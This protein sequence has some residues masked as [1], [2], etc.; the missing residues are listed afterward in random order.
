MQTT[1]W[2]SY[3][4]NISSFGGSLSEINMLKYK[5]NRLT[6]HVFANKGKFKWNQHVEM[7]NQQVEC[8][9]FQFLYRTTDFYETSAWVHKI[10][11][12]QTHQTTFSMSNMPSSI[13]SLLNLYLANGFINKSANWFSVL[14]NLISQSPFWTWSQMKWCLI[15]ICFALECCIGFLVKFITLVLSDYK[16]TLLSL[17]P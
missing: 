2:K 12:L 10:Y 15:S 8:D 1:D 6:D 11:M 7:Q 5:N 13:L 16:G 14:T 9:S 4:I 3:Q 17:T